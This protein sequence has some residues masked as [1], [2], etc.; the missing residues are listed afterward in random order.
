M[1]LTRMWTV[2]VIGKK[3]LFQWFIHYGRTAMYTYGV[4]LSI[5]FYTSK[6]GV[7]SG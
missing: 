1:Q 3:Q 6:V 7:G 2:D 4:E 5:H